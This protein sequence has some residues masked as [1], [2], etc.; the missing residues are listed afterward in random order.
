[1]ADWTFA[2]LQTDL[3]AGG[4]WYYA[5]GQCSSSITFTRT[6][7]ISQNVSLTSQGNGIAGCDAFAGGR[8]RPKSLAWTRPVRNRWTAHDRAMHHTAGAARG[9]RGKR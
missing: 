5:P 1:M 3:Q 8:M 6:I 7:A 4:D 9:E 2:A